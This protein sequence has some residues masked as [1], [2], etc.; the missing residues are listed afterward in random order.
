MTEA[1]QALTQAG[2]GEAVAD[3]QASPAAAAPVAGTGFGDLVSQGLE[4]V[5]QQ[6]LVSQKDLQQLATGNAEN[7]H[8][9]MIRLEESRL[10]F[11][12][13]L[14]VRNR[15]LEAYQDVMKMQV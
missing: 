11:Q 12:L 7:L 4:G 9:V 15:L 10:S 3:L 1:I 14:Q 6:L 2:N 5:N 13:L 8:Q